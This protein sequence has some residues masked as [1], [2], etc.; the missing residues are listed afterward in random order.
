VRYRRVSIGGVVAVT[1][2]SVLAQ[3][4]FISGFTTFS[5]ISSTVPGNGDINPYGVAVIPATMG[6]LHRGNILV[7]NF[8]NSSNLQGTG[9]T[10]VQISPKGS[11]SLFAQLD[12]KKLPGACPGGVGLTT[13]LGVLTQGWV[14]VGSLPSTDGNPDTAKAG[15][16]IVLDSNGNPV[17]TIAGHRINGPWDMATVQRGDDAT[18]S[19]TNVLNGDVTSGNPHVVNQG[20]VLRL[21]LEIPPHDFGNRMPMVESMMEIGSGFSEIAS[22][23]AAL[24]IGP[25]GVGLGLDGKLYV[26]DTVN[27][28]IAAIP[29]ALFRFDSAFAGEDVSS[30]LNL[31]GPLG[32]AIAPNG[33]ILTVDGNDG[34]LIEISPSGTQVAATM[35]ISDGGGDLFGLAV[36]PGGSGIYLVND[37]D[38][39]LDLFH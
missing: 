14:I 16:L 32:L 12:S 13:A 28:R 21:E 24:I 33:D 4:P 5:L 17:E 2:R 30:N 25:T 18:L 38:N 36:A 1:R 27:N 19:V 37:G 8:N 20:T 6:M 3:P 35:L 31:N 29:D 11:L 7:S 15:C 23:N 22:P 10:I 9:A 34:N 26:A 39:T